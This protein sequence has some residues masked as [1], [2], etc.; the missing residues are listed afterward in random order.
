MIK[1]TRPSVEADHCAKNHPGPVDNEPLLFKEPKYL[2]G[3]GTAK[4]F[5]PEIYDNY[6]NADVREGHEF[7]FLT[8]EMW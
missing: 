7:E 6:I 4:G 5:E 1:D 2:K 3:T 8:E